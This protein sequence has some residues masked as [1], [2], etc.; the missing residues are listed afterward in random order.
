[1]NCSRC[2]RPMNAHAAF[3]MQCGQTNGARSMAQVPVAARS[4]P[5]QT[6][7]FSARAQAASG[8][9][10]RGGV[11]MA[12]WVVGALACVLAAG[13]GIQHS[14]FLPKLREA[15]LGTGQVPAAPVLANGGQARQLASL[16]AQ[17][18][19]IPEGGLRLDAEQLPRELLEAAGA[20]N[21][22]ILSATGEP[23]SPLLEATGAQAPP[24]LHQDAGMP[25]GIRAYLEHVRR[26][27]AQR[28]QMAAAQVA[29]SVG[30]LTEL[31]GAGMS[32]LFDEDGPPVEHAQPTKRVTDSASGMRGPWEALLRQFNSVQPPAECAPIRSYYDQVIR[33]T[34]LMIL[35][36]THA[37]NQ[38]AND[39][40]QALRVLM[41]MQGKSNSR[42][43]RPARETDALIQ[44]LCSK[45]STRKWFDISGDI[46]AGVM[47]KGF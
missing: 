9:S 5:Q 12:L 26:C 14:G 23:A 29:D 43:D 28:S 18:S 45:Y 17:G 15:T 24:M 1:M 11:A 38:A 13:V 25:G 40:Q 36:I 41:S 34:G 10:A 39:R 31:Q 33:E 42:I 44:S 6:V 8:A 27:D 35:E 20:G 47:G 30:L 32:G 2:G 4:M 16:V 21:T 19:Q 46:G 7:Q 37:V 3:C 22:P